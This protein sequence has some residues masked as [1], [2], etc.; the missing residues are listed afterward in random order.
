MGEPDLEAKFEVD[1]LWWLPDEPSAKLPGTLYVEGG[2]DVRLKLFGVLGEPS[3]GLS[4]GLSRFPIV[5][6]TSDREK[7]CTL[8]DTYEMTRPVQPGRQTVVTSELGAERVYIG[9]HFPIASD[10]R[11][12]SLEVRYTDLE[13]WLGWTPFE[14]GPP[15]TGFEWKVTEAN[16]GRT[17]VDFEDSARSARLSI[18]SRVSMVF[19]FTKP[20]LEHKVFLQVHPSV[21][22]NFEWFHGVPFRRQKSV[23]ITYG[24]TNLC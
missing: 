8:A 23:H 10:L 2:R 1:G 4:G 16:L 19:S 11:F 7:P 6:G 13:Q 17:H 9:K 12:T 24:V 18:S 20:G 22:A 21:P 5:L 3:S 14:L 15:T